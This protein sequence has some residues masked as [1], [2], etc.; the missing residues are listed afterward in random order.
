MS[1]L[2][3]QRAVVRTALQRFQDGYTQRDLAAL[4]AFMSLFRSEPDIHVIGTSAVTMANEEWCVGPSAVRA[5]IA[6]DWQ[7]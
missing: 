5:L 7:L 1:T 3:K 4:D 2:S 6:A